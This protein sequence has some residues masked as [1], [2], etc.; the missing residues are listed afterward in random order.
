MKRFALFSAS[1]AA[2][3]AALWGILFL[4]FTT[5]TFRHALTITAIVAFAVQ[6]ITFAVARMMALRKQ[7]IAGWALGVVLRFLA[8]ALFA[9]VAAP[10]LGLSLTASLPT[11]AAFLFLSTLIEPL[12]LKP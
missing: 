1:C 12:F 8:L 6:L 10:R 9:L 11:L 5:P 4:L 2:L 7:M 3:I